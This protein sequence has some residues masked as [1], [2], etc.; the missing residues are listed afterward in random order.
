MSYS[1]S[2]SSSARASSGVSS[3]LSDGIYR[4]ASVHGGGFGGSSISIGSASAGSGRGYGSGFGGG[5]GFGAGFGGGAGFG[6]GS[7]FS[8]SFSAGGGGGGD[9]LL[10]GNEK[11]TMQNLNDRLANYLDK[12]RSLEEANN[13]LEAKI[14]DWYSKQ[15]SMTVR[16]QNFAGFYTSIDEL[17]D[18]IFVA[19]IN[20]SKVILEIDN[21]RLAADDF[22]LKYEN[23]LS[24]R[25]SVENDINGLRR[26][27]DE[28]TMTRSDLELQI[29]GLKEEL[30]YLKKNHE[31]EVSER[32]EHAA[33]TVNV[34]LDAA[35]GVDLLKTLNDLREQYEHVAEKNRREAEAWFLG[36]VES[37]QNE[38]VTSTQQVQTNKSESSELRRSYQGL[39]VEL[40]SLLSAKAGLEASVA[41]TE[42]RYAAQLFQI[43]TIISSVE[44]Q[45]ADLRS[46]LERQNQEYRALLDI[47]S[48]LEQEIA[49]Y[50]QLLEGEGGKIASGEFKSGS[51]STTT[52]TKVQAIIKEEIGGKVIS[53]TSLKRY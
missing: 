7:S 20:N 51:S 16:E 52:T 45:L 15:G 49:T 24:L 50:H 40:Q 36:Q 39:E 1:F 26:V 32:K 28:L 13:D 38:V 35:P 53:S 41:E 19:T 48:R 11:Y 42:G 17:R 12:V 27:L 14:R 3:R 4:A 25:Q 33:G 34:E 10:S 43:Q 31:E 44:A 22:R 37:L 2:Q 21:A 6:S 18:K 30:I 8:A 5:A 46:D 9:G 29:E 47:K 23:E